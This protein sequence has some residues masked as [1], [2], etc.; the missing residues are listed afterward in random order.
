MITVGSRHPLKRKGADFSV[1][2]WGLSRMKKNSRFR[3]NKKEIQILPPIT[4]T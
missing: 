2:G 1:I 3:L 4:D